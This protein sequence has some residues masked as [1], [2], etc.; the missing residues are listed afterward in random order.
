MRHPRSATACVAAALLFLVGCA[1]S[2]GGDSEDPNG[3]PATNESTK[4]HSGQ[5]D[6]EPPPFDASFPD[7]SSDA[8]A[9]PPPSTPPPSGDQCIDKDDPGGSETL[10]KKL[11]DIDDCDSSATNVKGVM[12]GAVDV[13][14]YSVHAADT[15]FCVVGPHVS[16]TAKGLEVC[17]FV[18]CDNS[19][20]TTISGCGGGVAKTSEIGD[21]GCCFATP[22]STDISLNCS[23]INDSATLFMRVSQNGGDLC[24]PYELDY[25]D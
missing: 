7:E 2:S 22:G 18:K 23:G 17:V 15:F 4:K 25:H 8:G 5:Q 20:A 12:N 10:A 13:D 1:A 6:P 9:T 21:P 19:G 11:P 14:Y 24:E 3:D 16:S